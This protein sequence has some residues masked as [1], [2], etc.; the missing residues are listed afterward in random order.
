[1][2]RLVAPVFVLLVLGFLVLAALEMASIALMLHRGDPHQVDVSLSLVPWQAWVFGAW[3]TTCAT[4]VLA[5]SIVERRRRGRRRA[6]YS[7]RRQ[8]SR[9]G[10][11]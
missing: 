7:A 1:V 2:R 3:F 9:S 6:A 11:R 5:G 4:V 8:A 10:S